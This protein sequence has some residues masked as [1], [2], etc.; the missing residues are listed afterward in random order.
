MGPPVGPSGPPPMGPLSPTVPVVKFSSSSG[1]LSRM[2]I[3]ISRATA[4]SH[5]GSCPRP[6]CWLRK[7][8]CATVAPSSNAA[9]AWAASSDGVTGMA[10]FF[11]SV[12]TPFSDT[13]TMALSRADAAPG[14]GGCACGG[15]GS[16]SGAGVASAAALSE[17]GGQEEEEIEA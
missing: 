11:G 10:N 12:N 8:T 1:A 6:G 5:V 17:E 13:V 3:A 4:G 9:R 2:A 7:W 15:T 16:G 14:C